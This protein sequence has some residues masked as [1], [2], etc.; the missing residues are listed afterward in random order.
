MIMVAGR[1]AQPSSSLC[2]TPLIQI[3]Y[4][5]PV[6]ALWL[7]GISGGRRGGFCGCSAGRVWGISPASRRRTI[8]GRLIPRFRR[9]PVLLLLVRIALRLSVW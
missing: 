3:W 7:A 9:L 4:D 6:C 1:T 2:L 5:C 8:V